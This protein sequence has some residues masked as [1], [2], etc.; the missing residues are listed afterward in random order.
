[1]TRS[2]VGQIETP[3]DSLEAD[4]HP[5]KPIRHIGILVLKISGTLLYL[6]NIVAHV[7][8][9]TMDVA[10]VLKNDILWFGHGAKLS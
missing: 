6:A 10:Q 4:V 5:I 9:R 1:M 2:R 7:V 8:D 3:L